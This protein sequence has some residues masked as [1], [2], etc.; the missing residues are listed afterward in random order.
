[1]SALIAL[2][3][4]GAVG[5]G[6]KLHRRHAR[7]RDLAP[8]FAQRPVRLADLVEG[9]VQ[10]SHGRVRA[11]SGGVIV[12]PLT[13]RGCVAYDLELRGNGYAAP[14]ARDV[15]RFGVTEA[16]TAAL[17]IEGDD[18]A[19][20][21]ELTHARLALHR[22]RATP[23]A[24]TTR[25]RRDPV[26]LRHGYAYTASVSWWEEILRP[27]EPVTFLG[28]ATRRTAPDA[29]AAPRGYRQDLPTELFI[30]GTAK[31]PVYLAAI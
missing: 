25:A 31:R 5:V 18:G 26:L 9:G 24:R 2:A 23:F 13:G 3:G 7:R 6:L 19:V 22:R 10:R 29:I 11:A 17:V 1:M 21:V 12:A 30:V 14:P 27:G 8:L 28:L 15:Q 16:S 20:T 4:L